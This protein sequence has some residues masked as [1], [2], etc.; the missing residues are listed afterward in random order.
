MFASEGVHIN[1]YSHNTHRNAMI[2]L[3]G[4]LLNRNLLLWYSLTDTLRL[5]GIIARI[6][7]YGC[8]FLWDV[9]T[10]PY[11][12]LRGFSYLLLTRAHGWVITSYRFNIGYF[13]ILIQIGWFVWVTTGPGSVIRQNITKYSIKTLWSSDG[14]WRHESCQLGLRW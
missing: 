9:I 8:G 4:N 10:H 5:F 3:Y 1:L 12:K 13:L 14:I 7:S 2:Y 6:N 11:P